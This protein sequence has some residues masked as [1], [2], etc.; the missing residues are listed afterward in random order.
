MRKLN[1]VKGIIVGI[2]KI[3]PGLSGAVM[4]ISLNLYDRAIFAITHFFD[5]VKKHF[6]FLLQFG[7]GVLIGVVF[8]SKIVVFF[9][10]HCYLYTI[11]FFIGLILGGIPCITK[12]F[13]MRVRNCLIIVLS[14]VLVTLLSIF[15]FHSTYVASYSFSSFCMFFFSGILEALGTV[16]PG[17][18]STALLMLVGTYSH[19]ITTISHLFSVTLLK[20]NLFFL[21]PFSLGLMIGIML[22]SLM[23][24]YLFQHY[25]E[26]TFASIFSFSLSSIFLLIIKL[27]P[28]FTGVGS[29]II[30]FILVSL[31]YFITNQL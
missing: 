4:M 5:D 11:A 26:Q 27:F 29:V 13:S 2:A 9:L 21:I 30:C 16:L 20:D 19:Y 3:I 28:F 8:F 31:G 14:F 7:L 22:I 15:N 25:K 17:V 1:F 23:V 12:N 10:T 6:L 18:S 24:N